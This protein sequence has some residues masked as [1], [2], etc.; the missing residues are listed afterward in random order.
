MP[1]YVYKGIDCKE[2]TEIVQRF[3][4]DPL[5]VCPVCDGELNKVFSAAPV[6][7]KGPGFYSTGG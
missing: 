4:D 6:V 1:T 3:S 5:K 2:V 7:F